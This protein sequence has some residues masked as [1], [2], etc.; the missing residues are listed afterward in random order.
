M[1]LYDWLFIIFLIIIGY[2]AYNDI[3]RKYPSEKLLFKVKTV[4]IKGQLIISIFLLVFYCWIG[5]EEI[6]STWGLDYEKPIGIF[7]R[8]WVRISIAWILIAFINIFRAYKS[9]EIRSDGI[10]TLNGIVGWKEIK[11]Y[12]WTRGRKKYIKKL[13]E[14]NKECTQYEGLEFILNR[15]RLF[16]NKDVKIV[17]KVRLEEK[18]DVE[19]LLRM[20]IRQID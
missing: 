5:I 3:K 14:K 6:V 18:E 8:T 12:N 15:E 13:G 17:W 19:K 2:V 4:S 20:Y 1:D 10:T 16:L 9:G 7:S 11:D